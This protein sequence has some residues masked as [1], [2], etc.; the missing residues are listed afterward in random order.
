MA[1]VTAYLG[2]GSNL[3]DR[4]ANLATALGLVAKRAHLLVVSS[5]YETGPWGYADQPDFLNC[6]CAIVT[7]VGPLELLGMT[8][9]VEKE[10]GRRPSFRFGPRLID[11]DI[12]LY[13]EHCHASAD[14]EVPHPRLAQRA[15]V[16]VP[17]AEIAPS[18]VHPV[19]RRTVAELAEA[20]QGKEGVR[21][22]SSPVSPSHG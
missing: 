9:G 12:L 17:L 2:L 6:A 1:Q 5:F 19:L 22:C 16:L 11:V 4:E 14:L 10:I 8:Q 3:G 20:V 7:S 13:G 21:W 15:F 18:V